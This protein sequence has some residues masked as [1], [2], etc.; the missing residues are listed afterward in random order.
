MV[1]DNNP[2]ECDA[3]NAG[4]HVDKDLPCSSVTCLNSIVVMFGL[5]V[6]GGRSV[7]YQPLL[8]LTQEH[9]IEAQALSLCVTVA[10]K[11]AKSTT[12]SSSK[13]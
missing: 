2:P 9:D 12:V 5:E 13:A 11:F 6:S 10:G 4:Q 1:A 7:L 8:F 3:S